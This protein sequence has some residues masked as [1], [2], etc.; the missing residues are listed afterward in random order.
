MPGS[1]PNEGTDTLRELLDRSLGGI[2]RIERELGRNFGHVH[3]TTYNIASA[4]ALL[5]EREQA[6]RWLQDAADNGFPCY[7]L[8]AADTQLDGL[9]GDPRFVAFLAKLQRDWEQRQ[10]AL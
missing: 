5:G 6:I 4:Y 7:P 8:F 1:E 10:R 3:H 9:R 2:Y